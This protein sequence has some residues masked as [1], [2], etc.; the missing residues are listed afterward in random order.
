MRTRNVAALVGLVITA[1][2]LTACGSDEPVEPVTVVVTSTSTPPSSTTFTGT[3]AAVPEAPAVTPAAAPVGEGLPCTNIRQFGTDENTGRSL[4]CAG[5]GAGNPSR[6][7]RHGE[8]AA[9]IHRVGEPCD[10]AQDNVAKDAAGKAIMCGGTT[11]VY[12]P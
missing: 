6:W 1:V 10:P 11:W 4:V 12:G 8:V 3:T 9:E 7:V 5:M 2:G